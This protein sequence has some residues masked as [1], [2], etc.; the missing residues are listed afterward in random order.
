MVSS[1]TT[2]EPSEMA[3]TEPET[4]VIAQAV[5]YQPFGMCMSTVSVIIYHGLLNYFH[6]NIYSVH[7]ITMLMQ[8]SMYIF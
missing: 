1:S 8:F 2:A 6:R 7:Y 3:V 5:P 4:T